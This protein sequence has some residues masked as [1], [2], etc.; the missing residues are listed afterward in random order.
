MKRAALYARVSHTA[1]DQEPETQLLELRAF[2][3]LREYK[4]VGE[5]VDRAPAW[6]VYS[7][8]GGGRPQWRELLAACKARKIDVVVVFKLDRAFRS[9]LHALTGLE[10]LQRHRVDFV[11]SSQAID[12]TSSYGR[13]LFTLL[14]AFA[15]FER[16]LISERTRA[17]LERARAEGKKLGRPQGSKNRGPRRLRRRRLAI[18]AGA[19]DLGEL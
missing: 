19:E 17:G 11:C 16:E 9:T 3:D 6:P 10:W 8:F 1:A 7:P 15:E 12:T 2:C 5:Y 18:A 13:L 4:I 14:S